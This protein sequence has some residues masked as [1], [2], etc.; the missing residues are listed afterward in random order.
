MAKRFK[1][2]ADQIQRLVPGSLGCIASDKITVGGERVCYMTRG[3]AAAPEDSGWIFTAGTETQAYMDDA[4]NFEVYSL[5]TIANY[6]RDIIPFLHAPPGAAFERR[7]N[8]GP[9]VP[10][11]GTALPPK[12]TW[13]PPGFPIVEGPHALTKSWSITLPAPYAR[14]IEDGAL[15]LWRPGI[16]LW[17]NAFNNDHDEPQATR[18]AAMKKAMSR[19]ATDIVETTGDVTRLRYRVNEDGQDSLNVLVFS[20]T[21]MLQASIYFDAEADAVTAA[22]MADSIT[23]GG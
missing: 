18:L 20:D 9:L 15:V 11:E 14:R 4:K 17:I 22:R 6:D 2:A 3:E 12:K 8:R 7:D 21:G 1:L 19:A 5:N 13:P 16:T 23:A 10:C